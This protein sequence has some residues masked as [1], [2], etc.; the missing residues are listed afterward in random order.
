[1]RSKAIVRFLSRAARFNDDLELIAV[2]GA[3]VDHGALTSQ[4]ESQ[5]FSY[6]D[7]ELQPRLA[8]AKTSEHNRQLVFGHLRKTVYASYI[9][10]LYEDFVE[11]LG[12]T[13][14]SAARKGLSPHVLRGEYKVVLSASD[15]LDCGSWDAVNGAITQALHRR[16]HAIGAVGTI[17]FLDKRLR[18]SLQQPLV[19]RAI[20]YMDLR[21]LLVHSDGVADDSFC[22]RYPDLA[23]YPAQSVRLDESVARDAFAAF[24]DLVE[25]IDERAVAKSILAAEDLN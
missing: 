14:A 1:M 10:D 16:L 11:F 13:V 4:D 7:P 23:P 20:R 5:L 15:L 9:K 25:H 17:T 8:K 22:L 19:D 24:A 2:I 12:E 21:H 6:I 3:S 18:L